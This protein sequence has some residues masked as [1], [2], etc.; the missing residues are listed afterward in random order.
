MRVCVCVCLLLFYL[1]VNG[2]ACTR[3]VAE[4][5][6]KLNIS[7]EGIGGVELLEKIEQV[8]A[9]RTKTVSGGEVNMK[10]LP[11]GFA[12]GDSGVDNAALI[13][14]SLFIQDLRKLQSTIDETVVNVQEYT[15]NPKTDAKLG[16]VG[17]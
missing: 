11:L 8:V 9:A 14:R 6:A 16:R 7:T 4:M 1:P 2:E 10:N 17:R 3:L 13:L 12:T 5:A 15:A